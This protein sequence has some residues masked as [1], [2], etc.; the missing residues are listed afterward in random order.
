MVDDILVGFDER[1][2][3][4]CLE[5]LAEVAQKTQVLVFTHHEMVADTARRLGE[6]VFVHELA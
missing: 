2:T 6:G 3:K 5:V 4:A 1:R